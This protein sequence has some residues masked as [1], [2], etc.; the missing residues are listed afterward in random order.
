MD[1]RDSRVAGAM[2]M[3]LGL[4]AGGGG[5]AKAATLPD[6]ESEVL[7]VLKSRCFACHGPLRQ[8]GNLR[9]DSRPA[10]LIGGGRG[11]AIVPGDAEASLLV[12]AIRREDELEMPPPRALDAAERELLEAWVEAGADW[13]LAHEEE[14]GGVGVAA[15]EVPPVE[16]GI[17]GP[18]ELL[19]FNRDVRPILSDHCYECHGPDAAVRQAGLRLDQGESAL[20]VL[21]SG[22][23]A[24]VPG[25]LEQSQLFQRIAAA[26]ALDRMPPLHADSALSE[27]E[28]EI[29]GRFILQGAEF[30]DHWA[31]RPPRRPGPPPVAD[32][33]WTRGDLDR[34]V[35]ARL[36]S[37]GL[38]PAPEAARRTLVRRLSLDLT[39][40]PPPTGEVEA[41][42]ADTSPEAYERL[43]DR[44]LASERYGEHMARS[45]L[46]AA[47]YADT[48]GYHID[49]ERFMWRWRDWVIDAF[50]ANQPFDEFTVDQLAGDLLP[51]PTP[52][53]L[54][55]T[56]FHRNH[57]INFEGGAI[58]EEYRVQYVFDR[59]DTTA[60]VWMGLTAGCAKCHDHKFDPISQ[61]EYYQLAAFFNTVDEVG[62]DGSQGNAEPKVPAPDPGQRAALQELRA[63]LAPLDALLDDVNGDADAV[64]AAW[65]EEWDRRLGERW[66][67][68]TPVS[69]ESTAGARMIVLDDGSIEVSGDNPTTDVY[70]IEAETDLDRVF[71]L[72]LEALRDRSDPSLGIGRAAD[73]SF[74]LT[75]I[76]VEATPLAGG[77]PR[78]VDFADAHADY[79][80][81][82]L[83][84]E[85]AVDGN[86]ETGWGAG[87]VTRATARTAV[88]RAAPPDAGDGGRLDP[89]HSGG[90]RLRIVLRQESSYQHKTMRR[91]RLSV[92]G[93][94]DVAFQS[95]GPKM[96]PPPYGGLAAAYRDFEYLVGL[97]RDQRT[98]KQATTIR[99][100]FR[101]GHWSPWRSH[102]ARY[103]ELSER[104]AGIEAA[105]PTT[106]V[107]REMD[108]P[109]PTFLLRRGE[110]D[111]QTD[112]VDAVVPAVLP[113]IPEDLPKNRL[114]LARWLVNGDHPLTA[115]VTANRIW[116][117]FF[118]RGLVATSGDFGSQGEWPSHPE[119][120][121][122]M[123]TELVRQEWDLK[124]LQKTIVMSSTYR[125][126]SKATP[127]LIERD[128]ENRLLARASRFR[129][130]AEVIRDGALA[131]SG[132]LVEKLGGPS[133]KPYQPPGLWREIGYESRGRFSAGI[134]E[135]DHGEALYRRSLYTFWK[136]T[137]PPP[138]MLVFD[139]PNR[140]T[141]VVERSRSNTPLQAL[142][143][144]ND[145]QFVEA[146][147]VL[148]ENL[149]AENVVAERAEAGDAGLV[150]GLFRRVLA[151]PATA[152]ERQAML[153]LVADLRPRYERDTAAARA[154][155]RVGERP[156]DERISS[157]ELAAWSVA[158]SAV[159]NLDEAVTRR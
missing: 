77:K 124:A 72:R 98:E 102:E 27:G 17:P 106:M 122:W 47:R 154:L 2:L 22:R 15:R 153:D 74:V 132:L 46:D 68:L 12:A 85:L 137:V 107:M 51:D 113:P 99:R 92:S 30:E 80:T 135:Q 143:L 133:V 123:A 26:D 105:V 69:L 109:R 134:F 145:P 120:L 55:A 9:L 115:R 52:E 142:V 31:Y 60:T 13:P 84:P 6:F 111:Q 57:M 11:A 144:M 121:D 81:P 40:L 25:S 71:A 82:S 130:D 90:A 21:P 140:E 87:Y 8:R 48:N 66:R 63:E 147:R 158:A 19:S 34:F 108:E 127:E 156:V 14:V 128:P 141:C 129:L 119:L 10:M 150:D 61:R 53:Q 138:N 152:V 114:G 86:L 23:R 56:G 104:L 5:L 159:L 4:L 67:T 76:E 155:L 139:A 97:P 94:S 42:L 24:L 44:L 101:R 45:W 96:L 49:N 37:E 88:F 20:G 65:Q 78:D 59:T 38:A 28:I 16:H 62:L 117:K 93:A 100:R 146:A 54:L 149:L 18:G 125:Q 110:Y 1:T 3:G 39:G 148:A 36:E 157:A 89:P 58:P 35:L 50:N 64:Q 91:F 7:P 118:G 112:E 116:Q 41:F 43:V 70:V 126:S 32:P 73:G 75:E 33:G 136:R 83:G 103:A 95:L 79:A 131:V 151:R 29:L